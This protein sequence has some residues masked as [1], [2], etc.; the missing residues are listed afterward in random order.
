MSL[1]HYKEEKPLKTTSAGS[2]VAGTTKDPYLC[3]VCGKHV[4]VANSYHMSCFTKRE[5]EKKVNDTVWQ[6]DNN[7]PVV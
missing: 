1:Q 5:S 6:T 2:N 7:E 3:S 4:S